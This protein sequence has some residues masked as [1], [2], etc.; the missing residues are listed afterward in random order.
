MYNISNITDWPVVK[1]SDE[2]RVLWESNF[3]ELGA[4]VQP[5]CHYPLALTHL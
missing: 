5:N 1:G 2:Y 4:H 3:V